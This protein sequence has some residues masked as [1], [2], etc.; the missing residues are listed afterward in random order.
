MHEVLLQLQ[1]LNLA[2]VLH[3]VVSRGLANEGFAAARGAVE[4][5]A[6]GRGVLKALKELGVQRR[7]F[8]GV[9][10]GLNRFGLAAD[11]LPRGWGD[12]LDEVLL[13]LGGLQHFECHLVGRVQPHLVA[14]LQIRVRQFCGPL[15][16]H[17][18]GPV[19]LG[20]PQPALR[21]QVADLGHR[22]RGTRPQ[23]AND[24][25]GF[26]DQHPTA[27]LELRPID[28]RVDVGIVLGAAD[29]DRGD[30]LARHAE[31]DADAIGRRRYLF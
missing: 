9:A 2:H 4:Q 18:L 28:A 19:R 16:D 29:E 25:V 15:H 22:P 8:N 21:Q 23:V 7:Q 1:S 13:A 6:L 5:K 20:N 11:A 26:V 27:D 17:L 24:R 14:D 10:D 30:P 3:Q 31:E 12:L